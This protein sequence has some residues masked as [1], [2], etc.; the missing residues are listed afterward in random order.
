[1]AQKESLKDCQAAL[2]VT[3]EVKL[4]MKSERLCTKFYSTTLQIDP[5]HVRSHMRMGK[6]LLDMGELLQVR[7]SLSLSLLSLSVSL[8][9]TL[10]LSVCLS[11]CLSRARSLA[12]APPP[13]RSLLFSPGYERTPP[14]EK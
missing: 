10:C 5:K 12:L 1:M 2:Q 9:R 11:V 8:A 3:S 14:G 7:I 6:T 13:P 4:S